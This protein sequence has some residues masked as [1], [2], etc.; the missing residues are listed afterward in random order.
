MVF[1]RAG[2]M[3]YLRTDEVNETDDIMAATQ[4]VGTNENGLEFLRS[5]YEYVKEEYFDEVN[6][7]SR[8]DQKAFSLAALFVTILSIV[9]GASFLAE[10]DASSIPARVIIFYFATL[11][12]LCLGC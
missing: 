1:F 5:L 4:E 7:K 11:V 8:H 3:I 9:L 10:I 12:F 6:R 2:D